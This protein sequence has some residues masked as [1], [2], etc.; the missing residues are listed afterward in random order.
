MNCVGVLHAIGLKIF[1]DIP[2][3]YADSLPVAQSNR[4]S[5]LT[6]SNDEVKKDL[7]FHT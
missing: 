4:S 7:Y 6:L 5:I 3:W 1:K 2:I